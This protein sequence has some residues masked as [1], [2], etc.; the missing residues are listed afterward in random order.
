MPCACFFDRCRNSRDAV[1]PAWRR[2]NLANIQLARRPFWFRVGRVDLTRSFFTRDGRWCRPN[3]VRIEPMHGFGLYEKL[4][5]VR[6]S[7]IGS[8]AT[9]E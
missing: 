5:L 8:Q 9:G 1:P 3:G 4:P 2:E 7:M 6:D